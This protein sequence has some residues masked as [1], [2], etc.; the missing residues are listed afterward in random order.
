MNRPDRMRTPR[1]CASLLLAA[2]WTATTCAQTLPY[3]EGGPATADPG[4]GL[5]PALVRYVDWEDGD[6][7]DDGT[8]PSSA[9]K[10]Q[11]RVAKEKANF[12]PGTHI[13][14]KRGQRWRG[15]LDMRGVHGQPG[16]RIVLGAYGRPLSAKPKI[17]G[18]LTV[19]TSSHVMVREFDC[20]K[21]DASGGAHHV[22]IFDN[23]VHGNPELN[24]W[25]SN[26]IRVFG[27]SH[28]I[29]IVQNLVYDL[30]ANDCIVVH[31]TGSAESARDSHWILDNV[32]IGNSRMEDG[33]D[34]A[35]S[36]P[37]KGDDKHICRD[38]KVV[39][40]RIQMKALPG[41]SARTG[42]GGKCISAGHDGTHIWIVGN[43]MGGSSHIG[44]KLGV[45]KRHCRVNGNVIFNSAMGGRKVT[46]ELWPQNL[47]TEHNT[48][49][50]TRAERSP[51][52]IAGTDHRFLH[53]LIVRMVSERQWAELPT[54]NYMK[55]RTL[56][57]AM[58]YN[59]YACATTDRG[60]QAIEQWRRMT[61]KDAH[62]QAGPVPGVTA[63][64]EHA[65]ADP[66]KWRESEFLAHFVPDPAWAGCRGPDTP[67]AFD[68]GGKQLG[69]VIKPLPGLP[70]HGYGW[71]GPA[72][73]QERLKQLGVTFG[74]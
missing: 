42:R 9:W 26:G 1:C 62:S 61:G 19:S 14:F 71:Q 40:N 57:V 20:I 28:H 12:K 30:K 27:R 3:A 13:L 22:L 35:M 6:D 31:P 63:P 21:L 66:R 2:A 60:T 70:N 36:E 23:I 64:D 41:L 59:W 50:H 17:N 10:S 16:K 56:I 68:C 39:C 33:V 49:I 65:F 29:A 24:E 67:G 32:C 25:P 37:D 15:A 72:L 18:T 74:Q 69:L 48:F 4:R 52:K 53:N 44:L 46:A 58:D 55:Q 54:E 34:L 8:S 51:L 38:I 73:V 11:K 5:P 43:V 45:E 7:G 47:R